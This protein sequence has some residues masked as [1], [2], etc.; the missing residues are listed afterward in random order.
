MLSL[1]ILSVLLQPAP[2]AIPA[3]EIR[4]DILCPACRFVRDTV[5]ILESDYAVVPQSVVIVG[6]DVF[7]IPDAGPD[8]GVRRFDLVT[9]RYRG[10]LSRSGG[11]PG[12]LRSP[13]F[14]GRLPGDSL[15]VFD[16]GQQR[17]SVYSP[18]SFSY[19]RGSPVAVGRTTALVYAPKTSQIWIAAPVGSAEQVGYP[20]HVFSAD[21]HWLRSTGPGQPLLRRDGY[22]AFARHLA[23]GPA[24]DTWAVTRYGTIEIERYDLEGKLTRR[25]SYAPGWSPPLERLR[26]PGA[27]PL[28]ER[29]PFTVGTD[30]LLWIATLVP[31]KN[32]QRG[33]VRNAPSLHGTGTVG[34][35][36][37]LFDSI[38]EV[39]DL[40]RRGVVHRVRLDEAVVSLLPGGLVVL[41][42]E[43]EGGDPLLWIERWSLR[44]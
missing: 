35:V 1:T 33:I 7:V 3:V 29:P 4:S 36:A 23:I 8:N 24:G 5:V 22:T 14:L 11:G 37:K 13:A 32:W 19:V 16:R 44:R 28:A 41:Y 18:G 17:F 15:L 21:G 42:R 27:P 31:E 38:I 2:A 10:M 39:L 34:D 25:Y 40:D 43:A 26:P 30:T 12:E 6:K 9:G 20:V